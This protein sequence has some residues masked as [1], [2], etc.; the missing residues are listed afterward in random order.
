MPGSIPDENS[1]KKR[2]NLMLTVSIILISAFLKLPVPAAII[3]AIKIDQPESTAW[4][5]W[6][7]ALAI[8]GYQIWRFWT[9]SDTTVS[10][11][12][13]KAAYRWYKGVVLARL[14]HA[15]LKSVIKGRK[16]WFDDLEWNSH[17]DKPGQSMQYAG[18][19]FSYQDETGALV[20]AVESPL[21]QGKVR[22]AFSARYR[23]SLDEI[24]A[25]GTL[26]YKLGFI[27][28]WRYRASAFRASFVR[29]DAMQDCIVPILLA[30]PALAVCV[31]GVHSHWT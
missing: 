3:S 8:L 11:N 28:R 13:A 2:R 14:L 26:D 10:W 31:I 19:L 15:R 29:S 30:I 21:D 16:L 20:N 4:K 18:F 23:P 6:V 22:V 1:N 9:D 7:I 25:I 17:S 27:S 12:R 5:I 24:G